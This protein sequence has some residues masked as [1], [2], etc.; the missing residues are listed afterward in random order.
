MSEQYDQRHDL[1]IASAGV[2]LG[3][4]AAATL[5]WGA[6]Q[7][8][9][10]ISFA[11][12]EVL[13]S[14]T[15]ASFAA[16]LLTWNAVACALALVASTRALP[17][18]LRRGFA[19]LAQYSGSQSTR[20]IARR[21]IASTSMSIAAL[22]VGCT[23]AIAAPADQ[24][25][26]SSHETISWMWEPTQLVRSLEDSPTSASTQG[27]HSHP[28]SSSLSTPMS[29][30]GTLSH[31]PL[32]S[33]DSLTTAPT[34]STQHPQSATSGKPHVS[35]A[36]H[37]GYL[38]EKSAHTPSEHTL[39]TPARSESSHYT[40]RVVLPGESLWTIAQSL[41]PEG[42]SV[43]EIDARWRSIYSH[44]RATLGSNPSLIHPGDVLVLP[45]EQS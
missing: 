26:H 18:G 34:T 35:P 42:A 7:L 5:A 36:S 17:R 21:V 37:S 23:G 16:F 15:I 40:R 22:G 25:P 14:S 13:L 28:Q 20:R 9:A 30:R 31:T 45:L 1:M 2:V 32:P 24:V 39:K 6:S 11:R 29:P 10:H 41:L 3:G 4:P 43:E 8:L 33:S 38:A 44:N 19:H 27:A 12:P